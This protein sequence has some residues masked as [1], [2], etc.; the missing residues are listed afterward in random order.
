MSPT[1]R[2]RH[3]AREVQRRR[4][5]TTAIAYVVAGVTV[6]ELSGAIFEALQFPSWAPDLVTIL[7][8]LGFPVVIVMAWVFDIGIRRTDDDTSTS[9]NRSGRGRAARRTPAAVAGSTGVPSA[10][11][12]P[13][14]ELSESAPPDPD[15]VKRAAIGHVRHEL[16]TPINAILGY[17]EMLLEDLDEEDRE[18]MAPDLERIRKGG[19]QLLRLID[20]TLD[21]KRIEEA[22]DIDLDAY[23]D[24][25]RVKLRNP[26]SAVI[27]YAELLIE[28]AEETDRDAYVDDL[29]RIRNAAFRLL[30]L[31][32]DVV[33]V[34][35]GHESPDGGVDKL[36]EASQITQNILL[37]TRSTV[38]RTGDGGGTL[39]VVDDNADNRNLLSRQLARAGF[40]VETA[41]DGEAALERMAERSFDLVL[42]DV[43]M[44]GVDGVETLRRIK[45]DPELSATPVIMLSSLDDVQSSLRCIEMGADDFLHKPFHPIL[46]QARIGASLELRRVREFLTSGGGGL[47]ESTRRM[48][49]ASFPDA[50]ADRVRGGEHDILESFGQA[51][52]LWCDVEGAARHRT[53]DP[54]LI[55]DRLGLLIGTIEEQAA[56]AGIETVTASGSGIGLVGGVPTPDD[57]HAHAAAE[58]ALAIRAVLEGDDAFDAPLRM[59]LDSGEV[60][61]GVFGRE[62]QEFRVWGEPMDVARSLGEQARGSCILVSPNTHRVLDGTFRFGKGGVQEIPGRGS[63]KTWSLDGTA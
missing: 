40:M 42:L 59:A 54:G 51:T 24:E 29:T 35:T 53:R 44:P 34:A 3:F 13:E 33:E 10:P 6:I 39:L 55:A 43:I 5:H 32:Q 8:L 63:L 41:S 26:I 30:E 21:P 62:R 27:G 12:D 20:G 15:R 18:S 9:G 46:L 11:L 1:E 36:A 60:T 28:Q 37:K 14:P 19:E 16:K 38:R 17:S 47:D 4:V 48:I 57:G 7:L 50:V 45:R 23:S 22:V 2:L 49:R 56:K 58:A 61:A 25:I 52:V 31:S